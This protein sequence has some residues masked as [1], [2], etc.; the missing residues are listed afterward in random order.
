MQQ[1]NSI[2]DYPFQHAK[3]ELVYKPTNDYIFKKLFVSN[4]KLLKAFL[5]S[6]L[7]FP[8]EDI[9]DVE[10][11]NPYLLPED[12]ENK[13]C[14]LDIKLILN[15]KMR[16]NL[17]MQVEHQTSWTNRSIIYLCRVFDDLASGD[18]YANLPPVKQI[19]ILDYTLFPEHPEFFSHYK[20]MN[21]KNN[22]I[23]NDKLE[24]C[25]LN[26]NQI[27]LA[28]EDDIAHGIDLWASFFKATTWEELHMLA[29][30]HELFAECSQALYDL[31]QNKEEKERMQSRIDAMLL[32]RERERLL[33]EEN[34]KIQAE[35]DKEQQEITRLR[36]LL[37][38]NGIKYD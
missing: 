1:D 25:V 34:E 24:L 3:G 14:I 2:S 13:I 38:A 9:H 28:T 17:E 18:D 27:N 23:Y 4:P 16:I 26:L 22:H 5:S 20:M 37:A 7:H 36:A 12:I 31:L 29:Q 19:G 10:I 33:R 30:E 15:K 11:T 21:V 6:L 35:R 8:L 32:V